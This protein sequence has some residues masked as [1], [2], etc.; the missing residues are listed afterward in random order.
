M[1]LTLTLRRAPGSLGNSIGLVRPTGESRNQGQKGWD[2]LFSISV[3]QQPVL[4][5]QMCWML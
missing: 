1:N 3:T 4:P 5:T 2:D